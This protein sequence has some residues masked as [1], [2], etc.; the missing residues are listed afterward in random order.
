MAGP[1]P[2]RGHVPRFP[3][4]VESAWEARPRI[5]ATS[6]STSS[7]DIHTV[8]RRWGWAGPAG[9][10][11]PAVASAGKACGQGGRNRG[12]AAREVAGEARLRA[13][14][15]AP[16]PRHT[17]RP[18]S[19]RGGRRVVLPTSTT[20]QVV[21]PQGVRARRRAPEANATCSTII[22]TRRD[23]SFWMQEGGRARD[24][25]ERWPGW[26]QVCIA[27]AGGMGLRCSI[28]STAPRAKAAR[29]T[30]R[31]RLASLTTP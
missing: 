14:S 25:H 19:P 13:S 10:G 7:C 27:S 16:S 3:P 26:H 30:Q 11:R 8:R 9:H 12:P 5:V 24:G 1:A 15:G 4:R 22:T 17:G 20:P 6:C 28:S 18:T 29:E 21:L 23:L 2:P 31:T